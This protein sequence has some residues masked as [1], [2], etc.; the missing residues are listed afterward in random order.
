M[1]LLFF[2]IAVDTIS[3]VHTHLTSP[4]MSALSGK[5]RP[6]LGQDAD[7]GTFY[8]DR[9]D[10]FISSNLVAPNPPP[11]TITTTRNKSS[12]VTIFDDDTLREKCAK[13]GLNDDQAASFLA[14]MIPVSGSGY[15]L[16]STRR[17][18]EYV[19]GAILL[20]ITLEQ[21][22]LNL[23]NLHKDK[24]LSSDA[25][26]C[27]T[28]THAVVGITFGIRIVLGA[29]FPSRGN[30]AEATTQLHLKLKDLASYIQQSQIDSRLGSDGIHIKGDSLP[31]SL[32]DL[33]FAVFS[34]FPEHQATMN[35][36]IQEVSKFLSN[37]P[38]LV[39]STN[40]GRG[41]EISYDLVPV[42]ALGYIFGIHIGANSPTIQ[43]S[44]AALKQFL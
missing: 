19:E 18:D 26:E 4:G 41:V 12:Q 30:P 35:I 9:T 1:T 22:S 32:D 8:D 11:Q 2:S 27:R 15:Y 43:P 6:A 44:Q 24:L 37:L 14:D 29:R 25:F 17:T 38:M 13:L 10:S 7:L 28:A 20:D 21:V 31:E 34:D 16:R 40:A 5:S 33:T 39:A 23:H 42:A 36:D 3:V